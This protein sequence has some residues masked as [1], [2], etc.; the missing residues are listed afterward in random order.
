MIVTQQFFFIPDEY[1]KTRSRVLRHKR[2]VNIQSGYVRRTSIT[3]IGVVNFLGIDFF[4]LKLILPCFLISDQVR[5]RQANA[6]LCCFPDKY[7]FLLQVILIFHYVLA[8]KSNENVQ[9]CSDA[10]V[11]TRKIAE[12]PYRYL[13]LYKTAMISDCTFFGNDLY[14]N[15]AT[16]VFGKSFYV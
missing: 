1:K 3:I 14:V 8:S 5:C 13:F 12:N 7:F 2:F 10:S 4:L 6:T 11:G 16:V 15:S 9:I